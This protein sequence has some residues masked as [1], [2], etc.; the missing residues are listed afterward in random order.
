MPTGFG[1]HLLE[2]ADDG[3]EGVCEACETRIRTAVRAGADTCLSCWRE[4][5]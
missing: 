3:P 1:A 4:Q 5:R 2:E